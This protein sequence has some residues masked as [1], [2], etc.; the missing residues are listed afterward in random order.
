MSGELTPEQYRAIYAW[1]DAIPLSRP[2]RNIARDFSDGC[3]LAEVVAAYFP[4]LVELHNYPPANSVK[5]KMYNFETLNTRVLKKLGFTI[6]RNVIEDIVGCKPDAVEQ[7][8]NTLQYKMAKYREKRQPESSPMGGSNT[9][10]DDLQSRAV[11]PERPERAERPTQTNSHRTNIAGQQKVKS[12]VDNE[13]L[14]EKEEQIRE[15]QETVEILE[16]K[17]AKLEQ[18]LRLKDS[19]IQKLQGKG[20]M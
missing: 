2:K 8:L 14:L 19:K 6:P 9:R 15:L 16:L 13:I 11:E 7:V 12:A 18:L 4:Q 5:Q 20:N 10:E 17:V 3:M 1:I